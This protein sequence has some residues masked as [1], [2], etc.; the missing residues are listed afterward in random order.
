VAEPC[1]KAPVSRKTTGQW[2]RGQFALRPKEPAL[3]DAYA[4]GIISATLLFWV[5][6]YLEEL[7]R[8]QRAARRHQPSNLEEHRP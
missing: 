8:C 3:P 2:E 1:R 6:P 7:L 5:L 4:V